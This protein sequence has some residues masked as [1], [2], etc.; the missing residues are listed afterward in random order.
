MLDAASDLFQRRGYA[1]SGLTE[2]IDSAGAPKGSLY[3]HFPRGKEQLGAEA[4]ALSGARFEQAIR[5]VSAEAD[6]GGAAV[7]TITATLAAGL[8]ATGFELGC[9]IATTVLET[10]A[11]SQPIRA[12]A[13]QAFNSWL[14]ALAERLTADGLSDEVAHERAVL[15]LSALEG[16]L[17]L[18]RAAHSTAPLET[19]AGQLAS[20]LDQTT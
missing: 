5:T 12:A 9:P 15:V 16:A 1:A 8:S 11:S 7:R 14:T 4:L 10:A 20:W 17:I 19:V 2:I 6:S 13:D 18:A 3:F